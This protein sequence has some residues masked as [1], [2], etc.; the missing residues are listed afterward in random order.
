MTYGKKSGL[1]S[2][3]LPWAETQKQN[4]LNPVSRPP[5]GSER[6]FGWQCVPSVS[7]VTW[8]QPLPVLGFFNGRGFRILV[9]ATPCCPGPALSRDMP[10][11]MVALGGPLPDWPSPHMSRR[12][13]VTLL[14]P[15]Q[16][17]GNCE[18]ENQWLW[19]QIKDAQVKMYS[20][21]GQAHRFPL[22]YDNPEN[23]NHVL[24]H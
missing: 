14:P 24:S 9:V 17:S 23:N 5:R 22:K 12:V 13:R 20:F 11:N 6:R 3:F 2:N 1:H 18:L 19:G 16:R 15:S 7:L 4:L 8:F 10:Q 21:P